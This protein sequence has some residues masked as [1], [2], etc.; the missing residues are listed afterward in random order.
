MAVE[1]L[2]FEHSHHCTH[3]ILGSVQTIGARTRKLK[4]WCG[5]RVMSCNGDVTNMEQM[6]SFTCHVNRIFHKCKS[7]K[8]FQSLWQYTF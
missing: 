3:I 1:D 5:C 7:T 2:L 8:K 4:C 6:G